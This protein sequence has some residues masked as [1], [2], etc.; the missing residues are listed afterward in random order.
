[1][2]ARIVLAAALALFAC[3]ARAAI[4]C[5]V[6]S[7]GWA[8]AYVPA[9]PG[10][11]ITQSQVTVTCRRNAGG[12]AAT[13]AYTIAV[14]NGIHATGAQNRVQLGATANR[15]NYENYQN[16][17]CTTL[18]GPNAANRIAGTI[19]GMV[20]FT[21]V[22]QVVSYW[23]CVPAGQAGP[24]GSYTDTETMTLRYGASTATGTFPVTVTTP[25]SC[26]FSTAPG[27]M[28]F[29]YTA[30]GGVLNVTTPFALTCTT[31]LPYTMSLDSSV[32]VLVGLRYTLSIAP[33]TSSTGTGAAQN[34]SIN[35]VMDAVQAGACG[36]GTCNGTQTRTLMITY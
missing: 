28:T 16:G 1:M 12:D 30:F 31:L 9:N 26:T 4:T 24:A 23:G 34:Y 15:L 17:T 2:I 33:V 18:W 6:S 5:T 14:N 3:G 13:Q 29:N 8:T 10:T 11:N 25:A 20:G 22:S 7:T 32:N 27:T 21:P 19:T 36:S 35:G